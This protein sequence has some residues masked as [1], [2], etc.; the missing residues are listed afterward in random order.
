MKS[1][2]DTSS[3]N[4]GE[5]QLEYHVDTE[6]CRHGLSANSSNDVDFEIPERD[7]S[8]D[9]DVDIWELGNAYKPT[10]REQL[11]RWGPTSL[12]YL[13]FQKRILLLLT[14]LRE[15]LQ[16]VGQKY[17]P[18]DSTFHIDRTTTEQEFLEF[19]DS[20]KDFDNVKLLVSSSH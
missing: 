7:V 14:E 19:E 17:E 15:R 3:S 9:S 16:D 5:E 18:E 11:A 6:S 1:L 4:S 8:S 10:L 12:F 20:L 13:E 2:A